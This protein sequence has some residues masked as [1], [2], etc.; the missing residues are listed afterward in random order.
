MPIGLGFVSLAKETTF[1]QA[2]STPDVFLPVK[3]ADMNTDPQVY[4]PEE[5]RASRSKKKGIAIAN[6]HEGSLEMDA[7]P[8]SLGHL[9]L[10][11][12][13]AVTTTGE[14]APYTHVFKP[15]N[16][17]PSYTYTRFDTIMSK[18][19]SGAKFDTLTLS[20]EAGSDGVMT[21]EADLVIKSIADGG[22]AAT[23]A[24]TD[25]SPFAFS[26][27][28]VEKGGSVNDNITSVELDIANNLK[29]DTYTLGQSKD[30]HQIGEGM[31]EVTGSVEMLFKNKAEYLAFMAAEKDSLKL[32]FSA[33]TDQL[34]VEIPQMS[35]DSFEVPMGG[36]DDEVTASLEFTALEDPELDAE[37][38]V[39]LINDVAT[40]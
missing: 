13:G 40:Y 24:Y 30:V 37:V 7:E 25:K 11:A 38:Q 3:S 18:V 16:T 10:A 1:G 19:A 8:V 15:A 21:A 33:G 39:T 26:Q 6:S 9:L 2:N 27:V 31:R 14:A 28:T 23:P 29:D 35:Y 34:I 20:V 22:A 17:L 36:P 5:I 32:T 4:Y 12:L